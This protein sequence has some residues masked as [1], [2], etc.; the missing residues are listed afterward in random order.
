MQKE[1]EAMKIVVLDGNRLNPGDNPWD[2][3]ASFGE[4]EVHDWSEAHQVVKRAAGA[5]MLLQ[6]SVGF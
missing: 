6:C 1:R 3:V 4:L 2:G 5:I